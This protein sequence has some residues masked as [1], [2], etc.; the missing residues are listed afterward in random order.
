MN[1]TP[2]FNLAIDCDIATVLQDEF[3]RNKNEPIFKREIALGHL[4]RYYS[5]A[6]KFGGYFEEDLENALA[7]FNTPCCRQLT[8]DDV[9]PELL[10]LSITSQALNFFKSINTTTLPWDVLESKFRAPFMSRTKKAT[11]SVDL[12]LLHILT[13]RSETDSDR[14]ALD[15]LIDRLEKVSLMRSVD[16]ICLLYTSPSPRDQRGSRMPSSA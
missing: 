14:E 12:D 9:K 8:P 10:R 3:L 2:V 5:K 16:Y 11:I 15:N 7:E 1:T 4:Q 13:L 6:R